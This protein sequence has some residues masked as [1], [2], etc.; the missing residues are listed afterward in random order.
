V[1]DLSQLGF[2]I[3]R[4]RQVT[5]VVQV[6]DDV[7]GADACG[8][9]W[10]AR[11]DTAVADIIDADRELASQQARWPDIAELFQPAR[12]A[13]AVKLRDAKLAEIRQRK[14]AAEAEEAA[15]L[16]GAAVDTEPEP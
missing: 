15:L 11:V 3:A 4:L 9:G 1:D 10:A 12:N 8:V 16:S 7:T 6:F 2:E 13:L 5:K 14:A